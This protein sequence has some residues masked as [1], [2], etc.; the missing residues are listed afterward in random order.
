VLF[1]DYDRDGNL[2]L[3]VASYIDLDLKTAPLLKPVL[4]FTRSKQLLVVP[5]D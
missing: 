2:D 1:V 3:F 4:V 5:Q